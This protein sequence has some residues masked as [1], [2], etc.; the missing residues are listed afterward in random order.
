MNIRILFETILFDIIDDHILPLYALL[1]P[2]TTTTTKKQQGF[3]EWLSKLEEINDMSRSTIDRI[4]RLENDIFALRNT[5]E[6]QMDSSE[7]S[8]DSKARIAQLRAQIQARFS[9]SMGA[10]KSNDDANNDRTGLNHNK[11]MRPTPLILNAEGRT[12]DQTGK[13]VQLIQRMPTLKANIRAQK[14][15]QFIKLNHEKQ[16][17]LSSTEQKFI[18]TRLESKAPVRARK[19]FR[20]HDKGTFESIGNKIRIKA[21]LELLQKDI[22][23]K[24]KRTGISAA[25]RLALLNSIV[26]KKQAVS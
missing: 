13:E 25:A 17:S 10:I 11:T 14:K 4:R 18:D 26:P 2:T 5:T 6:K 21:Q 16:S 1:N 3:N 8:I 24:A 22:A 20:F 15:E 19:T 9:N 7:S 12:V 23:Q